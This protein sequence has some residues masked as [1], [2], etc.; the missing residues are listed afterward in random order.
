MAPDELLA[1]D[2]LAAALDGSIV[3]RD[4]G[5]AHAMHDFD[6]V[7]PS[8]E[9]I[10]VEVTSAAEELCDGAPRACCAWAPRHHAGSGQPPRR[11]SP[12]SLGCPRLAAFTK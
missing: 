1:A 4:V 12:I 6:V 5:G 10:A 8:G 2:A 9:R 3:P 11:T 7:R